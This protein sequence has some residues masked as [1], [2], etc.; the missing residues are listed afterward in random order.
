MRNV[1]NVGFAVENRE[2]HF[3]DNFGL[4]E[5]VA[6]ESEGGRFTSRPWT[7]EVGGAGGTSR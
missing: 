6:V 7:D 1:K 3:F 5:G 4:R 2:G